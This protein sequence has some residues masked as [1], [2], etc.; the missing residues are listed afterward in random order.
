MT[1]LLN[2]DTLAPPVKQFSLSGVQYEVKPLTVGGYIKKQ[3]E[4]KN[5]TETDDPAEQMERAVDMIADAVPGLDKAK[6]ET[7]T[8]PQI[9]ALIEFIVSNP[10][11]DAETKNDAASADA[12]VPATG[13]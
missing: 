4:A 11:E 3:Q 10:I 13:N 7:L 5:V 6:I 8:M 2:L 1:K 9:S 12:G